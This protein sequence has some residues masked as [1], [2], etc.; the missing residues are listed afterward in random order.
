MTEIAAQ[1]ISQP[2][3]GRGLVLFSGGLDSLLAVAL[4][5]E[6]GCQVEG[7]VFGSP[8]YNLE[9]A[10]L[11]AAQIELPLQVID[12]TRDIS[13]LLLDPP[14]GFGKALNP[15]ID[16]HA[17]MIR[18]AG[19]RVT[20]LGWDFIA[21]GEVLNQRPMS[22]TRK[23]LALVAAASGYGPILVRPL[24]ARLLEPTQ[25]ENDGLI[26]RSR[27]LALSGRSRKAQ[28]ELAAKYGISD[29]P[30]A[31]G[32]CL[33]TER[34]FSAKLQ[35]LIDHEG[36]ESARNLQLLRLGRHFRLPQGSKCIAGR[37]H[38][39]NV[40]LAA[41]VEHDETLLEPQTVPGPNLLLAAG[42]AAA[43]VELAAELCAGFS[44]HGGRPVIIS[45]R[46]NGSEELREVVPLPR[47]EAAQWRV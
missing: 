19:Q 22:Q 3:K 34:M 36:L 29:Y 27:L 18:R 10:Q 40:R 30:T 41:A 38:G 39:E 13:G 9:Q 43:E 6:Q 42:A 46:R 15:C 4:L 7:V 24:S 21:T 35:D 26:D 33:L 12:F 16:C 28:L 14:H 11:S 31:G 25:P 37:D 2:R 47:T 5:R 44:D 1:K 32:G 23:A 20:E 17:A 45:C 8:F